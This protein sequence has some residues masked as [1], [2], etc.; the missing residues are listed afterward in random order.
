MSASVRVQSA[1]PRIGSCSGLRRRLPSAIACLV[2][3]ALWELVSRADTGFLPMHDFPPPSAVLQ[4]LVSEIRLER[5]WRAIGGTMAGWALGL[6][7]ALGLSVPTGILIGSSRFLS[8]STRGLIELLRSLPGLGLLP[9]VVLLLGIGLGLKVFMVALG[10]FWVLL[11]QGI[12]GVQE[13][14][15]VAK[16][17]GRVYGL[18]K[19]QT[20][21]RIQLPSTVPYLFTGL[22]LAAVIGLNIA[23]GVELV[24][25]TSFGM[26]AVMNTSQQ[27]DEIPRMYAY[28]VTVALLGV[29]VNGVFKAL[30][31]RALHWHASQRRELSA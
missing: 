31:K 18:S 13:T 27:I 11:V 7:I 19:G 12:Y 16:D 20:F 14:D 29:L 2:A 17:M 15:P 22:R 10:A 25:G 1:A 9:L 30:E 8:T 3:L 23:V 28:V 6:G 21:L 24:V 26:G 5:F 4:E